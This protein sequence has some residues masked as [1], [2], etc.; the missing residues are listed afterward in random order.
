MVSK[1]WLY[2]GVLPQEDMGFMK[3]ERL[4]A[5]QKDLLDVYCMQICI[6]SELAVLGC[7]SSWT[8]EDVIKLERIKKI[9][10]NISL[11]DKYFSYTYA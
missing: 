7:N 1:H 5:G 4:S 6:V 9:A 11:G 3:T 8:G 2:S 10:F